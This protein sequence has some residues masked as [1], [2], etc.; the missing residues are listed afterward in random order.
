MLHVNLTELRDAQIA[1]KM[2]FMGGAVR[3]FL[4]DGA[5]WFGRLNGWPYTILGVSK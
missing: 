1:G 3:V 4:Q 5:I 2:L